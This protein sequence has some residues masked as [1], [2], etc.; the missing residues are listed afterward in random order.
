VS[1][2]RQVEGWR[3]ARDLSVS[4]IGVLFSMWLTFASGYQ[5]VYQGLVVILAGMI[6]YAFLNARRQRLGEAAE[7]LERPAD[8]SVASAES[9]DMVRSTRVVA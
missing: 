7:P 4:A 5:V 9:A 8:N 2:R 6:G 1:R 3:L